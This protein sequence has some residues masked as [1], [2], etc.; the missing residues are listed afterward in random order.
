MK[1]RG[2]LF[3]KSLAVISVVGLLVGCSGGGSYGTG[4]NWGS[5]RCTAV[6]QG[7]TSF[8]GWAADQNHARAI[9]LD[10]CHMHNAN[11]GSCQISQ[12]VSE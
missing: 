7:G 8:I 2:I 5:F 10:K 4:E 3:S 9:A 1:N 12:C 6:A 11:S